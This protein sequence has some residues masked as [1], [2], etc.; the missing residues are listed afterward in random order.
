MFYCGVIISGV[1][2]KDGFENK[3]HRRKMAETPSVRYLGDSIEIDYSDE[4]SSHEV[5]RQIIEASIEPLE[6][7]EQKDV[8]SNVRVILFGGTITKPKRPKD[9]DLMIVYDQVSKPEKE[10]E[11]SSP[12]ETI[13]QKLFY[14]N[15]EVNNN[16]GYP[17]PIKSKNEK[18]ENSIHPK[19]VEM[20]LMSKE[21]LLSSLEETPEEIK[22]RA[23]FKLI[24]LPNEI[25]APRIFYDGILYSAEQEEEDRRPATVFILTLARA[26]DYTFSIEELERLSGRFEEASSLYQLVKPEDVPDTPEGRSEV[27]K[28]VDEY[29]LKM[30]NYL[31]VEEEDLNKLVA[32]EMNERERSHFAVKLVDRF[33]AAESLST[34]AEARTWWIFESLKRSMNPEMG[35]VRSGQLLRGKNIIYQGEPLFEEDRSF[36]S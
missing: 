8:L 24:D 11:F 17:L 34:E 21:S 3:E 35:A 19:Y 18:S 16:V 23:F 13:F 14:Y 2:V 9:Y 12:A 32:G 7:L 26:F 33:M 30:Q 20:W 10:V 22:K 36:L 4:H 5:A 31:D 28:R 25:T 29:I 15:G 27:R 1:E 6:E